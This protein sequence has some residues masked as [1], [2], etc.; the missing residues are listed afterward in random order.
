MNKQSFM[1][2]AA[3]AGVQNK[4]LLFGDCR[5]GMKPS[6]PHLQSS[7]LS[8]CPAVMR[9]FGKALL[10][11]LLTGFFLCASNVLKAQS[12]ICG[13]TCQ[14]GPQQWVEIPLC[15]F[16]YFY[17][18]YPPSGPSPQT[19]THNPYVFVELAYRIDACHSPASII[20]D[21]YVF[22]DDADFWINNYFL[23]PP[24][25][26]WPI[27]HDLGAENAISLSTCGY[28]SSTPGTYVP[29]T[30]AQIK[31]AIHDAIEML[32]KQ[33]GNPALGSYNIYFKGSCRSLVGLSFPTGDYIVGDSDDLGHRDTFYLSP[34][35]IVYQSIPCSDVCC[36]VNY[37]WQEV[38]LADG[39][40][41]SRWVAV[42]SATDG[43][44]CAGQGLPDY[45]LYTPKI[46]AQRPGGGTDSGTVVS[47]YPCE[48]LCPQFYAP[49]PTGPSTTVGS[50]IVPKDH[51]L[52]LSAG[53]LPFNN[54]IRFT[55]NKA[56]NKVVVTVYDLNGK[57]VLN[58]S[59]LEN[60]Q[61]NTSELKAGTYFIQVW[62][63]D[64][65]MKTIKAIKE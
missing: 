19:F 38:T 58:A 36:K 10:M 48:L 64:N 30:L 37:Q 42:S 20:I 52:Q 39:T 43:G 57:K 3:A 47:Q 23:Q 8:F 18:G 62:F 35:S 44:D 31:Q 59:C 63:P 33:L 11:L 15:W 5:Y 60:G 6:I 9:S 7:S 28:E 50:D 49:P 54:Y 1:P 27:G 4:N 61:L 45:N 17:P 56:M 40:T 32:L 55:S 21:D 53:P 25:P 2:K 41:I 13:D 46:K 14:P 65:T 51:A 22:V 16:D 12:P 24:G 34:G 26:T 29:P